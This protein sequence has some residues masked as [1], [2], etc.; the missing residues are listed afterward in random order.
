ML[1]NGALPALPESIETVTISDMRISHDGETVALPLTYSVSSALG[2]EELSAQISVSDAE[3]GSGML[4][5]AVALTADELKF[6][7][8]DSGRYLSIPAEALTSNMTEEDQEIMSKLNVFADDLRKAVERLVRLDT[9]NM[10]F[11]A[12]EDEFFD[13]LIKG[14]GATSA[15][16]KM[17]V[18]GKEYPARR[19][20]IDMPVNAFF[21]AYDE[22]SASENPA[23]A[24][25][26]ATVAGLYDVLE[27]FSSIP[28]MP[29]DF[30][31]PYD[32]M[33]M[34]GEETYFSQD[35]MQAIASS[36]SFLDAEG[37]FCHQRE[38]NNIIRGDAA[39]VDEHY[40][41]DISTAEMDLYRKGSMTIGEGSTVA[42][43]DLDCSMSI[44]MRDVSV[45]MPDGSLSDELKLS[46]DFN[47]LIDGDA[48]CVTGSDDFPF[49]LREDP[50]EDGT[51][52]CTLR[53]PEP[54]LQ[55]SFTG[56]IEEA[57][58]SDFFEGKEAI[59]LDDFQ[60]APDG[61]LSTDLS[62][63]ML[64]FASDATGLMATKE[65]T[66]MSDLIFDAVS[67]LFP[68]PEPEILYDDYD[69]FDYEEYLS[70]FITVDDLE[71]AMDYYGAELPDI[72]IPEDFELSSISVNDM[73]PEYINLI[74]V[75]GDKALHIT[76]DF[77]EPD[78]EYAA[79]FSEAMYEITEDGSFNKIENPMLTV[80]TYDYGDGGKE[81]YAYLY[82]DSGMSLHMNFLGFDSFEEIEAIFTSLKL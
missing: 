25:Y 4:N 33:H 28:F 73:N 35:G 10:D 70:H 51:I 76:R 74:Y 53:I 2:M 40:Y 5:M 14:G 82:H 26:G 16:V 41:F 1:F 29:E 78:P 43:A 42:A 60:N 22:L 11:L 66:D 67:E 27:S 71:T 47:L 75:S 64:S 6:A 68:M 20:S 44:T 37:E 49:E 50:Q 45:P 69:E 34:K 65:L 48:I 80:T 77:T 18:D 72:A 23:F 32:G 56:V 31:S 38:N 52:L 13:S 55:L 12:L 9:V 81:T 7:I 54:D 59:V 3:D 62:L 17:T 8:S 19:N 15:Y 57:P 21:D 46:L 58:Y 24:E 36:I 63:E 39:T 30:T 79:F 61:K